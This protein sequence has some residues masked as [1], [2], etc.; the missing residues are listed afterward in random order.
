MRKIRLELAASLLLLASGV[1]AQQ[2]VL[3]E[4][5]IDEVI[6]AMTL[7]EKAALLVGGQNRQISG[8]NTRFGNLNQLCPGSA[9]VTQDIGRLGVTPTVLSD[10]P[11]GIRISPTRQ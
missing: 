4:N 5:N 10:G 7:E 3:T 6:K 11:A 8:E 1:G 2:L 9:G